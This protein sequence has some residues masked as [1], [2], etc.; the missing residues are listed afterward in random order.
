MKNWLKSSH[1]PSKIS[2]TIKGLVIFI[3][4]LAILLKV[5][6][7]ETSEQTLIEIV[8][9]LAVTVSGLV[10]FYGLIRKSWAK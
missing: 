3:P 6:G 10:V 2:L 8:N 7:I 4:A 9:Q 5:F 1:D